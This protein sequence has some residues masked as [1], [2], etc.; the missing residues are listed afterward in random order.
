MGYAVAKEAS[1]RGHQVVL[2]SGPVSQ[3]APKGV[4]LIHV[5]SAEEMFRVVTGRFPAC[6]ACVMTAAVCDYRPARRLPHKL[7]KQGRA[8]SI[9]LRPTKDILAHLGTVKGKRAL[10]GFA[11]EDHNHRKNAEAKLRRKRCDA[12]V[13]NGLGNV[14]SDAAEIRI[15]R[16]DTGWSE[17]LSGTKAQI[18][19]AVVK[20]AESLVGRVEEVF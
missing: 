20:L 5:I 6:H 12:I 9:Q 4:E 1:R 7:E 19:K 8:R 3:P 16:A 18:A 10:V 11:M 2:V 17:P 14:G 13:L 15:L